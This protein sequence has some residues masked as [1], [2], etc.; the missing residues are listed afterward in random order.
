MSSKVT[1]IQSKQ[2]SQAGVPVASDIAML[3]QHDRVADLSGKD[4][5]LHGHPLVSTALQELHSLEVLLEGE[6]VH[7]CHTFDVEVFNE[8]H[9]FEGLLNSCLK[10]SSRFVTTLHTSGPEP[11]AA[12]L[13]TANN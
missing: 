13:G 2:L 10:C 1:S 6:K 8:R 3:L 11:L 12:I 4:S 7:C 9:L 5:P